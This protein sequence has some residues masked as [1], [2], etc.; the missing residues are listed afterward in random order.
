MSTNKT[1]LDGRFMSPGTLEPP[2]EHQIWDNTTLHEFDMRNMRGGSSKA[3]NGQR[4]TPYEGPRRA[5]SAGYNIHRPGYP[6]DY[7]NHQDFYREYGHQ[8]CYR[9]FSAS[10]SPSRSP[11]PSTI[12]NHGRISE[13]Q[14]KRSPE[15]SPIIR[16]H[17]R[18]KLLNEVQEQ[19]RNRSRVAK[20]AWLEEHGRNMP[21]LHPLMP[22]VASLPD[23][24][25]ELVEWNNFVNQMTTTLLNLKGLTLLKYYATGLVLC[26]RCYDFGLPTNLF[27][28][29]VLKTSCN[30]VLYSRCYDFGLPTNIYLFGVSD[31]LDQLI[32]PSEG[33]VAQ[34]AVTKLNQVLNFDHSSN[35]SLLELSM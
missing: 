26:S 1:R 16:C 21:C 27:L 28:F 30:P 17:H 10:Q 8:N 4:H 11:W 22:K 32:G 34:Q 29:G 2:R 20:A 31:G 7:S 14:G 6:R 23:D 25:K 24:K 3:P 18:C 15:K 35:A 12:Y 5:Q 13:S 9:N 33:A 19:K